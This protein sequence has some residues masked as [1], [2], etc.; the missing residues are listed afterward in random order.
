M[1]LKKNGF[2]LIEII[3]ALTILGIGLISVLSYLPVSLDASKKA[4]D[5]TI[6]ALIAQKHIEEIKAAS[7]N[8]IVS[9]DGYDTS[10]SFLA[11]SDYAGFSY[12]IDVTNPGASNSKDVSVSVRWSFKGKDQLETFKTMIVKYNPG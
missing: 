7:L 12:R 1:N 6:A 5:M 11:D 2:T 8:D 10:G 3:I 9:A 4:A